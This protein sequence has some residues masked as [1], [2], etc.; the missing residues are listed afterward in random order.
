[1]LQR[2]VILILNFLLNQEEV[3]KMRNGRGKAF[4]EDNRIYLDAMFSPV[5][6][7]TFDVEKTRVGQDIDY[8]KLKLSIITDGTE[9]PVDVFHYAVSVIAY[10]T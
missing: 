3:I 6:N 7:V 5:R 4:Q 2:V 10:S 9:S 8:D 1:M